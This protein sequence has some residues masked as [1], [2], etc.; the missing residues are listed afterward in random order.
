MIQDGAGFPSNWDWF[1]YCTETIAGR[2]RPEEE[3]KAAR[4]TR[5]QK[6]S[7]VNI[8]DRNGNGPSRFRLRAR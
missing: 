3:R 6:A 5:I 1:S 7:S 4:E 8:H 2:P